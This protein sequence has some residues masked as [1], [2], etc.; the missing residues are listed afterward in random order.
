MLARLYKVLLGKTTLLQIF[1]RLE[2]GWS[3][4]SKLQ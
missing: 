3:L 4:V 2:R 1:F